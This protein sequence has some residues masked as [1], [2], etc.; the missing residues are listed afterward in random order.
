MGMGAAQ[1]QQEPDMQVDDGGQ[2]DMEVDGVDQKNWWEGGDD[3]D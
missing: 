3:V 2:C 1:G